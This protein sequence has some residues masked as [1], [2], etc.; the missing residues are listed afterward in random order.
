M[1][2]GEAMLVAGIGCRRGAS[3]ADIDEAISAA[4]SAFGC[5]A[6]IAV[7]A[8]E[9]SK[10]DEDGLQEAARRLG[11]RVATYPSDALDAMAGSVLTQSAAALEHKGTRS[12]A[13]A[14]AL[15]AAGVNGRLLGPRVATPRA[16]CAF[17]IGDGTRS[18][19]GG[20]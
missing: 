18:D 20:T 11:V 3:V 14:A 6:P 5:D 9:A 4:R 10:S 8:T 2:G 17:A 13:E 16:T 12:V 1:A 15:L 19:G 7:I